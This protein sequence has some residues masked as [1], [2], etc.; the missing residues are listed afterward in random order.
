MFFVDTKHAIWSRDDM[1]EAQLKLLSVVYRV[2]SKWDGMELKTIKVKISLPPVLFALGPE[3]VFDVSISFET[4]RGMD[5]YMFHGH[6]EEDSVLLKHPCR[7][8]ILSEK[9]ILDA[10]NPYREVMV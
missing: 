6:V 9:D 1:N 5:S 8:T 7:G 10:L 4:V 3:H 2:L